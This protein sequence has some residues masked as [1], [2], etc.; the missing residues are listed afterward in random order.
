MHVLSQIGD[1]FYS[2]CF[3][4]FSRSIAFVVTQRL[5]LPFPGIILRK[6]SVFGCTAAVNVSVDVFYITLI[7]VFVFDTQMRAF[8]P[9][10]RTLQPINDSLSHI[11]LLCVVC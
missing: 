1:S 5:N 4:I 7:A 10:R 8:P 6:C 9:Y 11:S 3:T 2:V